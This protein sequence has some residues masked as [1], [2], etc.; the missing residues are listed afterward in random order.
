MHDFSVFKNKYEN[1]SCFIVG[2]APSVGF[3]NLKEIHNHVVISVNASCLLMPWGSG[4]VE[5]RFWI[6]NDVLCMKWS[7]FPKYVMDAK[8]IKL[9]GEEW[10]QHNEKFIGKD[11]YFFGPRES[12]DNDLLSSDTQL[13]H[14]SSV[15]SSIDFAIY[16]GCK[17]IY[18]LG[19]DQKMTQG[20][21]HFWQFWPKEKWP[22]R[23]DR[24][25]NFQPEQK[26]QII[27]FNKNKKTFKLLNQYAKNNFVTIKNCSSRSNLDVFEKISLDNALIE[28][29]SLDE[30]FGRI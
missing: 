7:Y 19:V 18:I 8:C 29:K 26:H 20:K 23:I 14:I 21:S 5:K 2:A 1:H 6:S 9:V 28:A 25:K 24:D 17:Q 27:V 12:Y 15:P 11:F 4:N 16:L 10:K 13:C 3:L 22:Q 30:K